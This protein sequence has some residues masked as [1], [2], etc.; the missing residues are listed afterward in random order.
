MVWKLKYDAS[1]KQDDH[2]S[3]SDETEHFARSLQW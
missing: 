2:G 3:G 1:V